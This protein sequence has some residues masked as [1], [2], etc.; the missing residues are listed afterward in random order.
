MH[1]KFKNF[2]AG[3]HVVGAF[4]LRRRLRRA[5]RLQRVHS[6]AEG[7]EGQGL[8]VHFA[9]EKRLQTV[10]LPLDQQRAFRAPLR[11]VLLKLN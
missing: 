10:R 11:L 5:G 9:R 1:R 7:L 6:V 2:V 3:N 8:R 4:V